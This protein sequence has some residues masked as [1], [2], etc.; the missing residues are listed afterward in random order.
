MSN[1]YKL[2]DTETDTQNITSFNEDEMAAI[3][4]IVE[5]ATS[6]IEAPISMPGMI[7][8]IGAARNLKDVVALRNFWRKL[9]PPKEG[10]LTEEAAPL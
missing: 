6:K 9:E 1:D 5:F 7:I 8:Y 4:R 10:A 3:R 2:I